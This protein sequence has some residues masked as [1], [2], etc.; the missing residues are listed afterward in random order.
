MDVLERKKSL[1]SAKIRNPPRPAHSPVTM[2][3]ISAH[4]IDDI[5]LR[6]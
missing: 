2:R 6:H 3:N 1:A 4:W 5:I